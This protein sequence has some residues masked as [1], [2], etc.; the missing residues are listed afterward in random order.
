MPKIRLHDVRHSY[1]TAALIAG[2]PAKVISERLGHATAAFTLQA[3]AHVIPGMDEDA[4]NSVAAL[5]LT[6]AGVA[7]GAVRMS[8]RTAAC[9]AARGGGSSVSTFARVGWPYPPGLPFR[10]R[11][12]DAE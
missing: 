7:D 6:G 9:W 10:S 4:A 2:V 1:A 11:G 12:L 5:I 3:Y 8:V